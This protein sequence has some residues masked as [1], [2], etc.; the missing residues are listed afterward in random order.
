M[1]RTYKWLG[2]IGYILTFIPYVNFISSILVA[3]AWILMGRDT[4]ERVFTILGVLMIVLFAVSIILVV[5]VFASLWMWMIP[6]VMRGHEMGMP[7]P[8]LGSFIWLIIAA[9][10]IILGLAIAMFIFDIVAHFRAAGIFDNRWFK[11]GGWLRIGTLIALAV[12][13]PL[14]VISVLSTGLQGLLTGFAPGELPVGILLSILWPLAIV[15]VISFLAIIFSIVAFFTIP[16][17][18]VPQPEPSAEQG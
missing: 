8:R 6:L 9:A 4:R 14:I 11:L 13:I 1:A 18:E 7:L 10:L 5:A 3:I 2:G 17:E 12:A 15:L 16:E